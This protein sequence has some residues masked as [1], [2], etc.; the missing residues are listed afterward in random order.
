MMSKLIVKEYKNKENNWWMTEIELQVNE[1]IEERMLF[2]IDMNTG[3]RATG[4]DDVWEY[5][6]EEII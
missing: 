3:T 2:V 6:W 4:I 1:R 5:D